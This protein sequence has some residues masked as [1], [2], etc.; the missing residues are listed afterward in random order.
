[1][2]EKWIGLIARNPV[3]GAQETL[4]KNTTASALALKELLG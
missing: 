1:M 4:N 2:L 3:G